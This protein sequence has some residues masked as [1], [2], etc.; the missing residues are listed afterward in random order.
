MT[1]LRRTL[2]RPGFLLPRL[3]LAV[4]LA[5]V[6]TRWIPLRAIS[7]RPFERLVV[8]GG[9]AAPFLTDRRVEMTA[10]GDLANLGG[11]WFP[12]DRRR[13]VFTTDAAGFRNSENVAGPGPVGAVLFGD[14]FVAGVGLSDG[15][16]LAARLREAAGFRVFNAGG[17]AG[18]EI[19]GMA[20]TVDHAGLGPGGV[21]VIALS[22]PGPLPA[23]PA[24]AGDRPRPVSSPPTWDERN[25]DLS[26]LGILSRRFGAWLS[27]LA[28]L[29]PGSDVVRR[30]I[31][32]GDWMLFL[33]RGPDTEGEPRAEAVESWVALH[34]ELGRRGF[35]LLVLLIPAKDVVYSDSL[36]EPFPVRTARASPVIATALAARGVH[37]LD[38]EPVLRASALEGL[39]QRR[40]VYWRDDTHW[41]PKGVQLAAAELAGALADV[42]PEGVAADTAG[43][44]SAG[45]FPQRGA[46]R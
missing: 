35:G 45:S 12:A 40:Y 25:L 3:F 26:R 38:L 4:V 20:G 32:N 22:E 33:S 44:G 41:S 43:A 42:K 18:R 9:D 28:R 15:E 39:P 31:V 34:R 24:L 27:G 5:D 21:V 29:E 46:R 19:V 10:V 2:L 30:R 13:E 1:D 37:V 6:G 7:Y 16:T 23:A 14:S 17:P 8:Y 36:E 11:V